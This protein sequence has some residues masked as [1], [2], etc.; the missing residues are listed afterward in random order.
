[1]FLGV[2]VGL[3]FIDSDLPWFLL[4]ILVFR[5]QKC[6]QKILFMSGP[7][8]WGFV[9][10]L[11]F[12][13]RRRCL[14][15]FF[16]RENSSSHRA[17]PTLH[18]LVLFFFLFLSLPHVVYHPFWPCVFFFSRFVGVPFWAPGFLAFF[19]F[20]RKV[21]G[22]EITHPFLRPF[23]GREAAWVFLV[24]S[25]FVVFVFPFLWCL[26]FFFSHSR[27]VEPSSYEPHPGSSNPPRARVRAR[28]APSC[29]AVWTRLFGIHFFDSL[30]LAEGHKDPRDHFWR[31]GG[32][33]IGFSGFFFTRTFVFFSLGFFFCFGLRGQR[34]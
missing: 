18:S 10:S 13:R 28:G 23:L 21:G 22:L 20:S 1:M 8:F 26:V 14:V 2:G 7:P 33:H 11:F 15:F 29:A 19:G 12:R 17:H 31:G 25:L 3:V 34:P 5:S 27:R 30:C 32:A 24:D 9:L 6:P 4:N 16:K